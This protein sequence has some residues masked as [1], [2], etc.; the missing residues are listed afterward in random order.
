MLAMSR[1]YVSPRNIW[2]RDT[3]VS[4]YTYTYLLCILAYFPPK[5]K[6]VYNKIFVE[7]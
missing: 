7:L 6:I 4:Y 5:I 2:Y 1:R 3:S